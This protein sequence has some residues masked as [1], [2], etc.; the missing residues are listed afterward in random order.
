MF[1]PGL[2]LVNAPRGFWGAHAPP[3]ALFGAS[4]NGRRF[5]GGIMVLWARNHVCVEAPQTAREAR[6]L[7]RRMQLLDLATFTDIIRL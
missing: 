2:R 7:P 6:A 4:P 1:D 3:R 5:D